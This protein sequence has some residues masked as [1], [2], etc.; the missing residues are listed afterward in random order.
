LSFFK[1]N[2]VPS[3]RAKAKRQLAEMMFADLAVGAIGFVESIHPT[4]LNVKGR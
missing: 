4:E 1:R 2:K 3:R